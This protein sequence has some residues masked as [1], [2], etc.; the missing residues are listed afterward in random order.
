VIRLA[1][2][3][4]RGKPIP[5]ASFVKH[6]LLTRDTVDTFYPQDGILSEQQSDSLLFTW[7]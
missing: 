1:L 3:K 5:P 2:D 4:L 6:A 7:H